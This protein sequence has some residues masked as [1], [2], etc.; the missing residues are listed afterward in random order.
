MKKIV[1][2]MPELFHGGAEKQFRAIIS[3]LDKTEYE[4][5]V[6]D[7][8]IYGNIDMTLNKFF[9][10]QN[11]EVKYIELKKRNYN[12]ILKYILIN[13]DM[14]KILLN[15]KPDLVFSS[16]LKLSSLC[17]LLRIPFVYS[18]RNSAEG[19]SYYRQK[20]KA[21]TRSTKVT[22]NSKSAKNALNTH[23]IEAQYIANGIDEC[24]L[25]SQK[26]DSNTILVPARI[27]MEKNQEVMLD[28]MNLLPQN[29]R[30]II[31]GKG[32]EDEY[33]RKIKQKIKDLNLDN[34]VDLVEFTN[35]IKKFYKQASL[36]VLP[37][38]SEG[39]SNVI[40]ESYMYGRVCV[41]SDI[42]QN[43]NAGAKGQRYFEPHSAQMLSEK[44]MEVLSLSKD[45]YANECHA[46]HEFVIN[47]FG[48]K[49]MV[50]KY[51]TV[52]DSV[53]AAIEY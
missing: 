29:I 25:L 30:L 38:L 21:L 40:L 11:K 13:F 46:N 33:Y 44:I 52:F 27:S 48:M 35:D 50:E 42:P 36:V 47:N 41:L 1:I 39:L 8:H 23:G 20:K 22:C 24:D 49:R 16:S 9:L 43:R 53:V 10:L 7:E 45:D 4:V 31:V 28:A 2:T 37:S 19:E 51:K 17:K 18:E 15:I 32:S 12:R 14:T 5:I 26:L 3:G 34:R 6:V